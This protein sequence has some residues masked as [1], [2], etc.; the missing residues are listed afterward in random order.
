MR[1]ELRTLITK[2][3]I[4]GVFVTHDQIEAGSMTIARANATRCC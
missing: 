3:G 1:S 4:T 2:L